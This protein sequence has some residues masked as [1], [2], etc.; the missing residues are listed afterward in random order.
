MWLLLGLSVLLATGCGNSN[1]DAASGARAPISRG[2]AIA[3]A[4]AVNLRASD[5]R[6]LV[7]ARLPRRRETRSGPFGSLME[8]CDGGV[9]HSGEVIGVMSQ[10]F[11]RNNAQHLGTDFLYNFLPLIESVY[12]A[13]YL[14]RSDALASHEVAAADSAR[15]RTCLKRL[16]MRENP[17]TKAEGS[18]VKD[19]L[20]TH[21][22]VSGLASP[23][24]GV[25]VYGLRMTADFGA[26]GTKGRSRDQEDFLGFAVGQTVITLTDTGDPRPFPAITERRLLALLYSRAKAHSL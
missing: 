12:S 14:M 8:S 26:P 1:V 9:T 2:Q 22:D 3:Y 21:I 10:T 19:P 15:A 6:G 11:E 25:P 7:G 16:F 4:E 5:V 17:T 13:V 24:R 23:L 20:F 18:S